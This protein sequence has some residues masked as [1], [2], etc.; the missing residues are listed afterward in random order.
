MLTSFP[1]TRSGLN[2]PTPGIHRLR[3]GLPGFLNPFPPH[4]LVLPRP[5]EREFTSRRPSSSTRRCCVR[6]SPIAQ[7]PL[8]LPPVGVWSVCLS[9]CGGSPSQGP[10]PSLAWSAVTSPTT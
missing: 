7:Y 3:H 9:Q 2:R 10:Y 8:L 5:R 6:L 1:P 4:A